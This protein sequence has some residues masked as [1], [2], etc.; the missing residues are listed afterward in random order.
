V[1][2]KNRLRALAVTSLK[3]SAVFP[4]VPTMSE[5]ALPGYDM[6]A[7]RSIMGPAGVRPDIVA[8]L[9]AA[10]ARSLEMP[11]VREK[12]LGAGSEAQPSTPEELSKQY[13]DWIERFGKIAKQAG[14]KPQ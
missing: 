14:L 5:A 4:E 12:M 1:A 11:D 8:S 7:W 13:A 3:R 6:P 10:I 9:N 2:Y